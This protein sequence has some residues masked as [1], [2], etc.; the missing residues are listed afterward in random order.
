MVRVQ[1][2]LKRAS[3]TDAADETIIVALREL[4]LGTLWEKLS[5]E[6]LLFPLLVGHYSLIGPSYH[7]TFLVCDAMITFFTFG[8][9]FASTIYF[10]AQMG[11]LGRGEMVTSYSVVVS[12][13][14]KTGVYE[15]T[16]EMTYLSSL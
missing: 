3:Q 1:G 15:V 11:S 4:S 2:R 6:A 13:G 5:F 10:G 7:P 12:L 14:K 16:S 9:L 8:I